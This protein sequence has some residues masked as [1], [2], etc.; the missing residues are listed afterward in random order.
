[1]IIP[2]YFT[3]PSES[4]GGDPVTVYTI[5]DEDNRLHDLIIDGHRDDKLI[6]GNYVVFT[7]HRWQSDDYERESLGQ[8]Y[9]EQ[10][11]FIKDF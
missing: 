9:R 7:V 3:T 4:R 2:S 11:H 8:L 1:M 6:P 5:K 10:L